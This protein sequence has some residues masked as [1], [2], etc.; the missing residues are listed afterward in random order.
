M[1]NSLH[2]FF[3][4]FVSIAQQSY[5]MVEKILINNCSSKNYVLRHEDEE[6]QELPSNAERIVELFWF[7]T[8]NRTRGESNIEFY[9][10]NDSFHEKCKKQKLCSF[11]LYSQIH[12]YGGQLTYEAKLERK[13]PE[14]APIKTFPKLTSC[15]YKT[16]KLTITDKLK[17]SELSTLFD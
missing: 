1:K 6:F 7:L 9:D 17:K 8:A 10:K 13:K 15:N 12:N 5:T 3:I 4:I 2:I 16:L 11:I 14:V